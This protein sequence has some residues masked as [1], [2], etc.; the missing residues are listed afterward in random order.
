MVSSGSSQGG[1]GVG[2]NSRGAQKD[3]YDMDLRMLYDEPIASLNLLASTTTA[4]SPPQH[5]QHRGAM[6]E[7]EDRLGYFSVS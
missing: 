6:E 1:V 7:E 2:G 5:Q 3:V 4:K